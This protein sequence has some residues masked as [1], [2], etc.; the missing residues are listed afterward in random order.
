MGE[1]SML[2]G[3]G[4]GTALQKDGTTNIEQNNTIYIL[5]YII[6][7]SMASITECQT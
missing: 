6:P 5:S 2:R 4:R 7:D 1:F 3:V